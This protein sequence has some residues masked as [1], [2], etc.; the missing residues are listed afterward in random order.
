MKNTVLNKPNQLICLVPEQ[1][2]S[3]TEKKAYNYMLLYAQKKL[4]FEDYEGNTFKIPRYILHEKANL[5]NDDNDYIYKRLER[6]MKTVVRIFREKDNKKEWKKSFT[7]LSSIE[8]T[9]DDFYEFE[10]NNHIINGLKNLRFFTPL[11]LVFSN[12]LDSQYSIIFYEL[13]VKYKK[14]K[15]PKMTIEEIRK[16]THTQNQYNRFYNF[17]KRVLDR[18]CNEIS[19]K[20]DIKLNYTTEKT[21]RRISH[22]D[23]EVKK[24]T[25]QEKIAN[26]EEDISENSSKMAQEAQNKF[27]DNVEELYK[28][29]PSKVQN[30]ANKK[31]LS[32]V[33]DNHQFK[34][35]AADI[36]LAKEKADKN[37]IGWLKSSLKKCENAGG[38]GNGGHYSAQRVANQELKKKKKEQEEKEKRYKEKIKKKAR[39]KAEKE[40]PKVYQNLSIEELAQYE[41][42][43]QKSAEIT[44]KSI[45]ATKKE[46]I[47]GSIENKLFQKY[48]KD[49]SNY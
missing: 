20:T 24:K 2:I 8:K 30:W 7:L 39:A 13:A 43:Y 18:A 1:K 17:R 11:D 28:L 48:K 31:F 12:C 23:F 4:K 22:I 32:N 38:C 46:F 16:L 14:Y 49:M 6:L 37:I 44:P 41:R 45:L 40:A 26:E 9:D 10:L 27:S 29:L 21:G 47:L 34:Y 42:D 19:E 3:L 33:L 36:E 25:N 35:I 5:K 15:I